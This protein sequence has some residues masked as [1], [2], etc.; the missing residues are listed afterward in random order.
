GY[1]Y[2]DH[3]SKPDA[4]NCIVLGNDALTTTLNNSPKDNEGKSILLIHDSFDF[5][6]STYLAGDVERIDRIQLS[7][8]KGSLRTYIENNPPDAVVIMYYGGNILPI[9][10]RWHN[11]FFDFR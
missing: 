6:L 5:Y 7:G 3:L 11:S 9:D 4:Y 1:N 8:F 10:W 2:S